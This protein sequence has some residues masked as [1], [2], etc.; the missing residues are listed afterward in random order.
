MEKENIL[1]SEYPR[2]QFM[3]GEDSWQSLNGRWEFELDLSK[4]GLERSLE[5]AEHLK[6][7]ITVPFVPESELSGVCFTDF[8]PAVWYR[9]E[10]ELEKREAGRV[11]LHFGAVNNYARVYVNSVFA[12][13]HRGGY[14][15]FTLDVTEYVESGKNTVTVYAE[16]DVRDPLQP[17]GKQSPRY[18]NYNCFYTRCTGIWQSVWLE[19]VPETY[20]KS[21]KLIPD[22]TNSKLDVTVV[23]DGYKKPA[24]LRAV[25]AFEGEVVSEKLVGVGS[26]Q[27]NL[28][29]EIPDCKLW[30]IGEGNLYDLTLTTEDDMLT[31]YF[32]M[33][34]ITIEENKVLLN[35]KS[36]FQRLVLDQGYYVGGIYTPRDAGEF[37][38]DIA[39]SQAAGFNG[40]RMHMKVFEPAFI[41]AADRAGYLLW[42]EF[43]NWGL[44]AERVGAFE[45]LAP[46]WREEIERDISSP[47]I[48]GWCPLNEIWTP[49]VHEFIRNLYYLTKTLDPSRPAI[50]ISGFMHSEVTDIYDVHDYEQNA[51]VFK[52]HYAGLCGGEGEVFLNFPEHEKRDKRLPYFVSEFGG[53][54]WDPANADTAG[55]DQN[56]SW[57]YGEKPASREEFYSRFDALVGALLD[58]PAVCGFCYTQFTDVMQEQN[59]LFCFDRTP[60][61]DL[62]RLSASVSRKAAIE[63]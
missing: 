8:I 45:A 37:E 11:L 46:S 50:D 34:K 40:A 29:L 14:T 43:P 51:D 10:F 60:K 18:A 19:F 38:R 32:G 48:I 63:D 31:S 35:G 54:F 1:R 44:D 47:S 57:G 25:A 26:K 39:L 24:S 56:A 61:F 23:F 6:S 12:G 15:P 36:I 4:S 22:V 52:S 62:E 21:V 27:V 13:E 9:R 59:G 53:T 30:D 33:R 17:S 3:R 55:N 28:S 58:N 20:I 49:K 16:N 41:A 42:G 7:E 5:K 2:P